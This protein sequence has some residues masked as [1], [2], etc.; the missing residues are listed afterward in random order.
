MKQQKTT[1]QKIKEAFYKA[2]VLTTAIGFMEFGTNDFR[3]TVSDLRDE[4]VPIK[5]KRKA[6]SN[7]FEYWIDPVDLPKVERK[8]FLGWLGFNS[9]AA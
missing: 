5:S 4:G 3:K 6:N 1:K 7:C 2:R 8:S 9:S